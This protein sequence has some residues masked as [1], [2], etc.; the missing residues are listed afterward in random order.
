MSYIIILQCPP[1]ELFVITLV[2]SFSLSIEI[3]K[4]LNLVRS[5]SYCGFS[6]G[7]ASHLVSTSHDYML[8]LFILNFY[9]GA[10]TQFR[11]ARAQQRVVNSYHN[12]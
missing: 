5:D 2:A 8:L 11:Q 4:L 9:T 7:T 3:I 6:L 10:K 1:N 12:K